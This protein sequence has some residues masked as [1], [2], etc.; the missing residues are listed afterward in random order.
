MVARKEPQDKLP[1]RN[2]FVLEDGDDVAPFALEYQGAKYELA[3]EIT[4]EFMLVAMQASKAQTEEAAT[5]L[6]VV[7]LRDIVPAELRLKLRG[8]E[9]T[10]RLFQAWSGHVGLGEGLASAAS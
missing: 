9:A 8:V 7:F 6:I 1:K 4:P 3:G 2:I 5:E 10:K